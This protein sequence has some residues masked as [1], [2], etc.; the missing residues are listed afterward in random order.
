MAVD[1]LVDSAQLN[2]D[3]TDIADA[4]RAKT[5]KSASMEFPS[6]FVSEIGS[7]SGGGGGSSTAAGTVTLAENVYVPAAGQSKEFPGIEFSFQPDLFAITF[8]RSAWD[9]KSPPQG[10][11]FYTVLMIK[12][13]LIPPYRLG[14][15]ISTDAYTGDYI[16]FISTN[17]IA[18]S[19]VSSNAYAVNGIAVLGQTYQPHWYLGADGKFYF[20]RYSSSSTADFTTGKYNYFGIKM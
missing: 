2:S 17:I 6:E 12:K 1:K 19:D 9:K 13:T 7:I 3:L 8:D 18:S 11:V 14:S 20:G 16:G 15:N 5:G 4:I 10:T